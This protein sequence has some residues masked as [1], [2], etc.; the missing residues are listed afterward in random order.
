MGMVEAKTV[1]VIMA[2]ATIHRVVRMGQATVDRTRAKQDQAMLQRIR[3]LLI[4]TLRTATTARPLT[5][6]ALL[7]E[8]PLLP[9]HLRRS[10][11]PSHLLQRQHLTTSLVA[12][13]PLTTELP[14][15]MASAS[16][17]MKRRHGPLPG[18]P[19]STL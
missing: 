15:A 2:E 10:Q 1:E 4:A 11:L 5:P 3:I 19:V 13:T 14:G 6:T 7:P 17:A 16:I 18:K 8:R 12:Q 9:R